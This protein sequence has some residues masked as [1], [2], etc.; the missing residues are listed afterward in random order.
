MTIH[1]ENELARVIPLRRTVPCA[2][3]AIFDIAVEIHL[4]GSVGRAALALHELHD[5]AERELDESGD[6]MLALAEAADEL[7]DRLLVEHLDD[8]S[9]AIG[10][11]LSPVGRAAL[12]IKPQRNETTVLVNRSHLRLAMSTASTGAGRP[13][14][15]LSRPSASASLRGAR[16]ALN[17]YSGSDAFGSDA[18]VIDSDGTLHQLVV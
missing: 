18:L 14:A 11:A 4:G 5:L 3:G 2:S 9:I 1:A 6:K 13:V 15:T 17:G 12:Q 7:L 16:L 10:V 8:V